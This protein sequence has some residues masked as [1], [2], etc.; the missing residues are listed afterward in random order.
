MREN[1]IALLRRDFLLECSFAVGTS[2][3]DKPASAATERIQQV[4]VGVLTAFGFKTGWR[5]SPGFY[6][7]YG[8]SPM[9]RHRRRLTRRRLQQSSRRR[10]CPPH[11]APSI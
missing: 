11:S 5:L 2:S 9:E 8:S 4:L 10:N 3:E 6:Y 7:V 1:T